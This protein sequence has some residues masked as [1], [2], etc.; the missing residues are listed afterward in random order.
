MTIT[1]TSGIRKQDGARAF[2]AVAKNNVGYEIA[3]DFL[4]T[5]IEEIAAYFGDGFSTLSKMVDSVTTYMNK[6]YQKEQFERFGE[7]ARKLGLKSV[8]QS[9]DRALVK[10][11]NNIHWRSNSYYELQKF[12]EMLVQQLHINL[13]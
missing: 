13:N 1:P 6:E 11:K 2:M 7:K 9:I 12:L 8:E 10:V 4:V 5:N 3:L